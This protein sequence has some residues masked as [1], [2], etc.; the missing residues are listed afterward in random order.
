ML[1]HPTLAIFSHPNHEI[2]IYG[3]AIRER[4]L[5]AY[6]TDGGGG[7]RLDGT[8]RSLESIGIPFREAACCLHSEETFYRALLLR[9]IPFWKSV[10]S[11]LAELILKQQPETILCDAVEYYNP[12]HDMSL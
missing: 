3:M 9:E 1:K 11:L 10:S 12:V 6:L 7:A 4:P 5:I 2:S 8:V